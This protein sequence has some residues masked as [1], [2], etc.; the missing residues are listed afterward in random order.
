MSNLSKTT[1]L[2]P[3]KMNNTTRHSKLRVIISF[4]NHSSLVIIVE[5]N[6][7]IHCCAPG[8]S[9]Y[10]AAGKL[11]HFPTDCTWRQKWLSALPTKDLVIDHNSM[12]CLKHFIPSDVAL[13]S[14]FFDPES[15]I[16]VK[17]VT[18]LVRE[19]ACPVFF[20]RETDP[21]LNELKV[22]AVL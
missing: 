4:Y 15:K 19:G 7:L 5:N 6:Q 17:G 1:S 22:C 2:S 13:F 21:R 10:D 9:T 12:L 8:C 11:L 3:Q 16:M 14:N 18:P 20:P